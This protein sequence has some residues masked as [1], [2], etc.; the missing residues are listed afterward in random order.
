MIA[1]PD[2]EILISIA[3]ELELGLNCFYHIK[4]GEVFSLPEDIEEMRDITG[5]V[6]HWEEMRE[7]VEKH[8][9][10]FIEITAPGSRTSF[11]FMENFIESLPE[12]KVSNSL[13]L[14]ISKKHPFQHFTQCLL[15][16]PEI[17]QKWF[18][19]KTQC[20]IEYIQPFFSQP[21]N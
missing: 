12:N 3:E 10:D 16:Y 2:K 6:E 19:F 9:E 1:Q 11:Q 13:F 17:R 14:A 8:P 4:T 18:A 7:Q 15:D 20:Y 5:D 21:E